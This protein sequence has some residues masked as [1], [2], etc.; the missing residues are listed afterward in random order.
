MSVLKN[1]VAIR[2]RQ[3]D[4][5]RAQMAELTAAMDRTKA[6]IEARLGTVTRY[7]QRYLSTKQILTEIS[8]RLLF[9]MQQVH[10]QLNLA[11]PETSAAELKLREFVQDS[12][13]KV[14]TYQA[15]IKSLNARIAELQHRV[16]FVDFSVGVKNFRCAVR[17]VIFLTFYESQLEASKKAERKENMHL[18]EEQEKTIKA[19]L[20]EK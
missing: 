13:S 3:I 16:I 8:H 20:A 7:I 11:E 2:I 15:T 19:A 6:N 12:S 1:T 18:T 5:S 4:E 17:N 9:R 10:L 14:Q